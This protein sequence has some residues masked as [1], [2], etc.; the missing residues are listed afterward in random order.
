MAATGTWRA[1]FPIRK[2]NLTTKPA[3]VAKGLVWR[4]IHANASVTNKKACLIAGPLKSVLGKTH[5]SSETP[6]ELDTC[7]ADR[8]IR[9]IADTVEFPH[10]VTGFQE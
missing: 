3:P 1:V 2:R 9:Y 4:P 6:A 8:W 10:V 5:G 7:A